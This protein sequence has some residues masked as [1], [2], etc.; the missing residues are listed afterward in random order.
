MREVSDFETE[1]ELREYVVGL[2][3]QV[4]VCPNLAARN[5]EAFQFFKDLFG[6]HPEKDRKGVHL[7]IDISICRFPKARADRPLEVNDHQFKIHKSD[8]SD[9]TISWVSCVKGRVNPVGKK[10]NW[11]MREAVEDQIREFRAGQRGVPCEMC[12]TYE[13]LTVD[14]IKKFKEIKDE[15]L[16]LRTDHPNDFGKNS[17]SQEIFRAEDEEYKRAWQEYHRSK[18]TLRILCKACNRKI[19][20]YGSWWV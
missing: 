7:L 10:L 1:A 13:D 19:D 17:L 16:A 15:F 2:I 4:G 11:A 18:A 14:H 3:K 12:E 6:R 9:D 5:P 20:N 8:G